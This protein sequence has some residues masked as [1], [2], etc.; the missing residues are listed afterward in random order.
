MQSDG[1]CL[2]KQVCA[3][4]YTQVEVN[5]KCVGA[6]LLGNTTVSC[7]GRIPLAFVDLPSCDS[8][9]YLAWNGVDADGQRMTSAGTILSTLQR[10]AL[11]PF[12]DSAASEA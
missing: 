1:K 2:N 6:C 7:G 11:R 8:K 9:V 3:L 12:Y 4:P 10:F 5:R